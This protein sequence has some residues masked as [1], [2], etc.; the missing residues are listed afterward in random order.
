MK[1]CV[2]REIWARTAGNTRA[3]VLEL[4][5]SDARCTVMWGEPTR[6]NRL[7]MRGIDD[8]QALMIGIQTLRSE[9]HSLMTS[10]GYEFFETQDATHPITLAQLFSDIDPSMASGPE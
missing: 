3:F 9:L 6:P 4:Q 2:G 5:L 10:G 1:A 8:W 7:V